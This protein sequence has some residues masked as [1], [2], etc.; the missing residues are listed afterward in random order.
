MG[1]LEPPPPGVFNV[2]AEPAN[3]QELHAMNFAGVFGARAYMSYL[4][5]EYADDTPVPKWMGRFLIFLFMC[6]HHEVRVSPRI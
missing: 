6:E 1:A 2:M 4:G 3:P 5:M